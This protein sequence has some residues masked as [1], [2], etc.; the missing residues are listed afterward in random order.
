MLEGRATGASPGGLPCHY[1]GQYGGQ[2]ADHCRDCRGGHCRDHDGGC[3]GDRQGDRLGDCR[4]DHHGDCHGEHHGG[5]HGGHYGASRLPFRDPPRRIEGEYLVALGGSETF[6][7]AVERPFPGLIGAELGLP[8]LNL[9]CVNAGPDLWLSGP[10]LAGVTGGARAA[11]LQLVGALNL[12]NR[13]Y[14]VHPRRNDRFIAARQP[15]RQLYREVDFSEINFTRH[16]AMTLHRTCP[17]RFALVAAELKAVWLRRMI[18]VLERMP[19]RRILYWVAGHPPPEH[20][21]LPNEDP[22]LVDRAMV[23]RLLPLA[24]RLVEHVVPRAR[25]SPPASG[26][27]P[28]PLALAAAQHREAA[29]LLVPALA[30]ALA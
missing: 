10:A 7:R 24:E 16:L 19:E 9:G 25:A 12:S 15:L 22:A 3:R 29:R 21:D 18:A 6:G 27:L 13:F 17:E 26:G 11:V 1:G 28:R 20:A 5:H 8:V 4:A 2:F 14:T 30:G 23:A